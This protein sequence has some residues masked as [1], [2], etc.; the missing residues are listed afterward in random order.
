MGKAEEREKEGLRNHPAANNC[1]ASQCK[2]WRAWKGGLDK[3]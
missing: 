1:Q 2:R 3:L